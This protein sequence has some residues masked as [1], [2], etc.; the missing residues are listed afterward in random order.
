MSSDD[1]RRELAKIHL[2]AKQLGMDRA[3]YEEMLWTVARTKSA[4]ALDAA[5]RARVLDH[6]KACGF[7][8]K[9]AGRPHNIRSSDRRAQLGKIEA[10]L[11]EAKR[12]WSY[13]DALAKRLCKVDSLTF[14]N[15]EQLGDIIAALAYDAQRHGRRT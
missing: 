2:A 10:F 6:L 15:A 13:A 11:A 7:K 14:C 4:G 8:P 3:A 1:R 12:P 9:T 5:G